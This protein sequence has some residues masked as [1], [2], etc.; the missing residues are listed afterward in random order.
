M[1]CEIRKS[2]SLEKVVC[3]IGSLSAPV[4]VILVDAS[5][6][7]SDALHKGPRDKFWERLI[8][9][10]IDVKQAYEYTLEEDIRLHLNS[11]SKNIA[12]PIILELDQT[13]AI[14]KG[15]AKGLANRLRALGMR[16][17]AM[18]CITQG[19]KGSGYAEKL[20]S[21]LEFSNAKSPKTGIDLLVVLDDNIE[22]ED[23]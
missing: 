1:Y 17:V 16:R 12:G 3:E 13:R 21:T 7:E 22:D 9:V 10:F 23:F 14:T 11:A 8:T 20:S 2:C 19:P 15:R 4:G 18:V 5:G 6:I